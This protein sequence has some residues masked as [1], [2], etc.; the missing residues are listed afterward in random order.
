MRSISGRQLAAILKDWKEWRPLPRGAPAYTQLAEATRALVL[1]GRLPLDVRLPSERDLASALRVSRTT[2]TA[3]YDTLRE[4]GYAA[5]KRGAGTW[6]TLPDAVSVS[7]DGAPWAPFVPTETNLINLTQAS[8]AAP[9]GALHQAYEAALTSLPRYLS[10]SGYFLLGMPAARE[11]VAARFTE[12]GLPTSPDQILITA[13]AQHAL[14][15]IVAHLVTPGDRVLVEHPTYPNTLAN[16]RIAGA[17]PVPVAFADEGWDID[18]TAA[19]LRQTAP[20]LAVLVPDF[21]NP[22]GHLATADERAAMAEHLSRTRTRTVIDESLV[23]LH[24]DAAEMPAP[25][26]T[27]TPD[28][29]TLTIG[30]V[31]KCVWGGIRVGW[32]RADPTMIQQLALVRATNDLSSAAVEQ[33]AVAHLLP[34]LTEILVGRHHELRA[35]R[36]VLLSALGQRLPS[37]QVQQPAGGLVVWADLGVH[38]STALVAAAKQHGVALASGALFGVDGGFEQ[39]LRIPYTAPANVLTDAVERM[40]AAFRAVTSGGSWSPRIPALT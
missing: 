34:Q 5:S 6:I 9:A 10:R 18:G 39:R 12:R 3:A 35:Q 27:F 13:G 37:W 15:L 26:A 25:F 1:D 32:I 28:D 20:R 16:V 14:S 21:N 24:L 7:D 2:V 38:V 19:A 11:A 29:L 30:S 33:L 36:D 8:P 40:A 4:S 31:D 17:R 23:D 22:T